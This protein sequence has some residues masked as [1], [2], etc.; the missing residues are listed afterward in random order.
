LREYTTA[1]GI[2]PESSRAARKIPQ[3]KIRIL[4][5]KHESQKGAS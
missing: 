4:Q 3:L 5:Q 1:Y 2:N